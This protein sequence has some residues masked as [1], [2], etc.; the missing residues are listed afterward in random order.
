MAQ[1][2][3]KD[4]EVV[5]ANDGADE[6]VADG[7]GDLGLDDENLEGTI[8]LKAKGGEE[9]SVEKKHAFISVLVRTSIENDS[10]ATEVPLPGVEDNILKLIVDYMKH[11]EGTELPPVESPLK[12][13][14]MKE[15][16]Q[17][18]WD[19]EF[20]DNIGVK[21]QNL[22]DLILAANYMD[23]KSCLHLGLAKVASLIKGKPL[24]QL[25]EI[26]STEKDDTRTLQD[27]LEKSGSGA[28]KKEEKKDT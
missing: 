1:Q 17:D 12:S 7:V 25:K 26:L 19:A 18:K 8:K 27:D 16:C 5:E 14:V 10:T 21:R 28:K 22:Y 2:Q 9:H 20:I 6:K 24:D 13:C 11:H 23:I 3:G 4:K 15:V